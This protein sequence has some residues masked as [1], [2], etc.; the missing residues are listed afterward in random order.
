MPAPA[1]D[2]GD[3]PLGKILPMEEA[4]ANLSHLVKEQS[5]NTL[6]YP[7]VMRLF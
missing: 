4:P 6:L 3:A 7:G 2:L 5:K 1:S